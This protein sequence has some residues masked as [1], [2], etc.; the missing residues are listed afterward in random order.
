M[1]VHAVALS[2]STALSIEL[3]IFVALQPALV[4]ATF[5]RETPDWGVIY[6]QFDH[7]ASEIMQQSQSE[8]GAG[9]AIAVRGESGSWR[10][11]SKQG[12]ATSP[13]RTRPAP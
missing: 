8:V 3:S 7:L 12:A 2:K 11:V 5:V 9:S 4:M 6:P 10:Q 13:G 1:A